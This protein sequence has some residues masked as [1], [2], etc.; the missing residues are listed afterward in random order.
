MGLILD[1]V[2]TEIE[3]VVSRRF[4]VKSFAAACAAGAA[5]AGAPA[6]SLRPAVRPSA[7]AVVPGRGLSALIRK[8]GLPGHVACAVAD[9]KSGQM[10]EAENGD[11]GLPP[12]SVAKALTALYALDVLGEG[13]R[14]ETQLMV[15]GDVSSGGIVQG[16]LILVGGGDPTL[17][18]TDLAAMAKALKDAGIR[19]VRGAFKVFE[20]ALPQ[21]ASID[22]GQPDHVGYSPA[23]SGIALNFNRVHF[24]WK[25]AGQSWNVSMQARTAKYR[26]AV[27]TASMTIKNRALP[28][29]TY[30]RTGGVDRW[31]VAKSALGKDGARW[32]PVRKPGEYAGDVFRTLARSHGLV[33]PAAKTTTVR[34]Q[35]RLLVQHHSDP[36]PVILK[37]M[38]KYSNNLTAE[39]TGM[40]ATVRRGVKPGNLKASAREMCRWAAERYGM[41]K[42]ALVD[43]SGLGDASRMTAKDLVGGLVKARKSGQLRPLLKPVKLKDAKGNLI[44]N[45]AIK[46]DAKTGTLNFVSGLG[47]FMTAA[48]GTELA[49]AIFTA[50][51]DARA[52]IPRAERERPQGARS[53]NRRSKNLQQQLIGR[54]GQLYGS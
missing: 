21:V 12:A 15:T 41:N 9:I 34:P 7:A 48:D 20:G 13:Y 10:L 8:A 24:E 35:G 27:S 2:K 46:A 5:A 16:D 40:T 4:F 25:K 3:P 29:Y 37:A 23:V 44:K 45:P 28:V 42:T 43:H 26:P 11:M 49:F 1:P 18:T 31:T 51:Q 54:W 52:K 36:L 22:P 6:I 50:D 30:S 53:W 19:E 17:D 14:F 39:M 38:L 33:L 32:L 47:G